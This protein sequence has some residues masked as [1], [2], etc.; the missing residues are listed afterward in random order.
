M[1]FNKINT[2]GSLAQTHESLSQTKS[3]IVTKPK[4]KL[5]RTR[6][7]PKSDEKVTTHKE[8]STVDKSNN[9]I[10]TEIGVINSNRLVDELT[11][12]KKNLAPEK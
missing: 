5:I 8:I 3:P 6:G 12:I 11:L 4:L 2:G 10:A 9:A 7:R 1:N